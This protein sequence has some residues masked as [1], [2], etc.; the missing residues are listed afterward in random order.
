[1]IETTRATI[2]AILTEASD[3]EID[4]SQITETTTL[5]DGLALDS[6]QAIHIC[7]DLETRFGITVED[8][9]IRG[10]KT[11]GDLFMLVEGSLPP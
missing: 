11:V 10:L 1:M 6:M 3:K 4:P 7:L 8:E 2:V 5:R 9:K